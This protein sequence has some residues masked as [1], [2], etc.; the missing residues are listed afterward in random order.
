MY[1]ED[2]YPASFY[3][4]LNPGHYN[5]IGGA[6]LAGYYWSLPSVFSFQ[7]Y[8]EDYVAYPLGM[9]RGVTF[10]LF[11]NVGSFFYDT[12]NNVT[13]WISSTVTQVSC[14]VE[15]IKLKVKS[16]FVNGKEELLGYVESGWQ[17]TENGAESFVTGIT[18]GSGT[19]YGEIRDVV[20]TAIKETLGLE[21]LDGFRNLF[22]SNN[23]PFRDLMLFFKDKFSFI[24]DLRATLERIVSVF[25]KNARAADTPPVIYAD[26]SESDS[27]AFQG[28]GRVV[29][30]DFSWYARYKPYVDT[31]LS[32][33]LWG[34][35]LFRLYFRLP[36][37]IAGTGSFLEAA[38]NAPSGPSKGGNPIGFS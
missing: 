30:A 23:D 33:I 22:E 1:S 32:A 20:M 9:S 36:D 28:V 18:G 13:G 14:E 27:E 7:N 3:S 15:N 25:D 6:S 4:K 12:Y 19:I 35:F 37:I 10:G 21:W 29:V 11:E 8:T 2:V 5:Q 31:F 16:F 38:Q 34:F 17:S 26:F 24:T